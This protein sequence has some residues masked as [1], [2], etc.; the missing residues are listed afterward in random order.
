MTKP[1]FTC[2]AI[3]YLALLLA[4]LAPLSPKAESESGARLQALA[5][6][7]HRAE[8]YASRNGYRHPVETLLFF[9][10]EPGMTVVEI[11]PGG[12]GWYTEIIAPFLREEG[13][14]YAANYDPVSPREYYR[15][16]ARRFVD[17]LAARGDLYDHTIVTVFAPPTKTDIAPPGSA[18]LVVVFRNVHN[19]MGMGEG[20]AQAAFDAFYK[21][22]KP[23]G[24]LGVVQHRGDPTRPQDP[25]AESGY[26]R[27][28]VV[29]GFAENAGFTLAERSEIN[30]N[31]KDTKDHP[32][33]VWTLPPNLNLGEKD[34]QKYLAIGESDRMTLR[35][36][37][38]D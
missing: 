3:A 29:I 19:W 36:V 6:G 28:D 12:G 31:P 16:N 21:A 22:L 1:V 35:L 17:K 26:V 18:D 24:I 20:A 14:Y 15:R 33:G 38:P 2:R 37:K 7:N 8:G 5:S 30:A 10:L 34:R 25:A 23:G 4:V 13:R 27:E 32:E 9:G 11:A